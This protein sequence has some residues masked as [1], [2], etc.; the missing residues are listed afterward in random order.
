VAD[1]DGTSGDDLIAGSSGADRMAGRS[2]N[3]TYIV[4]DAGDAVIESEDAPVPGQVDWWG[5]TAAEPI[6]LVRVSATEFLVRVQIEGEPDGL[7]AEFAL[8]NVGDGVWGINGLNIADSGNQMP[9]RTLCSTDSVW[10]YVFEIGRADHHGGSGSYGGG[11][12]NQI[13]RAFGISLDGLDLSAI[14]LGSPV[15]GLSLTIE[16]ELGIVL[17]AD[18]T[19]IA[20]SVS[21]DHI[22]DR[23][24]MT[25]HHEQSFAPGFELFGPAGS[26]SAMLPATGAGAG[27]IDMMQIGDNPPRSITYGDVAYDVGTEATVARAWGTDHN[28]LITLSLPSGGPD[29]SGDWSNSSGIWI[30]DL[31]SAYAYSKIYVNW[32]ATNAAV[33]AADS[34][35]EAHYSVTMRDPGLPSE[36]TGP[37]SPRAAAQGV[38]TVL[39]SITYTLAPNVEILRLTGEDNIDGFGN[40]AN[41]SLVGNSGD[42]MLDGAGGDNLLWGGLGDDSF[43][44]RGEGDYVFERSD[45]GFDTVL[46]SLAVY[47]L[48]DNVE[49]LRGL[50]EAG[51]IGFGNA[52]TNL[53]RGASGD[54]QLYGKDGDDEIHGGDGN[55][56][57]A[58]GSGENRLFGEAGNDI[59]DGRAGASR[60]EGGGGHDLYLDGGTANEIVE[61]A[62]G[63]VDEV[64]TDLVSYVLPAHVENLLYVGSGGLA[65]SGNESDNAIRGGAANDVLAGFAGNDLLIGGAGNDVV[66]GGAGLNI[67]LGGLG[68]DILDG[69]GGTSTLQGGDGDD[70]YLISSL[71]DSIVE[72]IGEGTD[73]ILTSVNYTLSAGQ[74]IE[75]LG[76][77]VASDTTPVNL[78]GNHAAQIIIGNAGANLLSGGGGSDYLI[79]LGGD[80]VLV[81]NADAPSTLQ[82]GTGGDWYYI[83]HTGDS[84]VEAAGEGDDRIL[85]A[86]GYTLSKGQE[87]ETLMALDPAS[88]AAIDLTGNGSSQIIQ[89]TNGANVLTGGG[90]SDYLLGLGGSDILVGN[91]DAPST[92]QG[93]TGDDWYYVARAGDSIVEAPGEGRDR[94]LTGVSYALSAGQ[95][96]E[97][98]SAL[99]PFGSGALDL[100]GNGFAQFIQGTDGANVLSGL[101][102]ADDLAGRGGSDVLLGGDGGD[103]LNGGLGGD[104]LNGGGGSDLFVF[105][106]A[107]GLS[108]IDNIQDFVSGGDRIALDHNIFVGLA[109]GML[110]GGA[111]VLGT[112]PRDADDRILYDQASGA[113]YYDADGSGAGAAVQFAMLSGHPPLAASDLVVI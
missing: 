81:G 68:D 104:V 12:G 57:V 30:S 6:T 91:A 112:A 83:F 22:F 101:G 79:G 66:I 109:T 87:I 29:L 90:G 106:D 75:A 7:F 25:I 37:T 108:N 24:G 62:D 107:L 20:G 80:D 4:N 103:F 110:A 84:L 16:Q 88:A 63:G 76:A 65:A 23:S 33:P 55:D 67:L 64:W 46:T 48:P 100:A 56:Y 43:V 39:A 53:M 96:I 47:T 11:H 82:G 31:P 15:N 19:T 71:G 70:V 58:G 9:V 2:G 77:S 94:V 32:V 85:T 26:Y 42:N 102:G 36:V 73:R 34:A 72:M 54:D 113:L 18:G 28:Y 38:D 61:H 8:V 60:M 99:D 98:L 89:G 93:G 74:A 10:E 92:L 59:L 5:T 45:E 14:P 1:Y 86:A 97:T 111:F 78:G 49:G 27:G 41:N 52:L 95:E 44:V 21:L 3:D 69:R 51:F 17:P 50:N 105:A 13:S 35:H 40:E